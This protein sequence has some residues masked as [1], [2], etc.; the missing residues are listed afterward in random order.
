[1][2]DPGGD[3]TKIVIELEVQVK[4]LQQQLNDAQKKIEGFEAKQKGHRSR[5]TKDNKVQRNEIQAVQKAQQ[6]LVKTY[7]QAAKS[8]TRMQRAWGFIKK[9]VQ[10]TVKDVKAI[11]KHDLGKGFFGGLA[12]GTGLSGLYQSI[13]GQPGGPGMRQRLGGAIGRGAMGLA[14]AGLGKIA[15]GIQA[16][17]Q[18]YM[19]FGASQWGMAGLGSSKGD[20]GRG[21][22]AFGKGVG[23]GFTPTETAQMAPGVAGA[24]GHLGATTLAQQFAMGGGY[25]PGRVG[26]AVQYM[27]TMRQA[28]TDFGGGGKQASKELTKTISAGMYSGLEKARLPEFYEGVR[29]LV[30]AQFGTSAGKVDSVNIAK[31]L[32]MIGKGGGVGFQGARGAQVMGQLDQ[33]I[34]SP[35]GGEA[36]QAMILQAMGF[37]KPGGQVN[38]Y[39]ALK[40]QQ[41][42]IRDPDNIKKVMKEVYSQRGN[43][44]A[45]GA[46]PAN[47]EANLQFSLMSGLSIKQTEQLKDIYSSSKS[48]EEK[49]KEIEKVLEE[50]KPIQE[51]ALEASKDGFAAIKKHIAGVEA[52]QIRI[53]S[54]IAKPMMQLQDLQLKVLG[55]IADYLPKVIDYLKK[56]WDAIKEIGIFIKDIAMKV[57]GKSEAEYEKDI[58]GRYKNTIDLIKGRAPKTAQGFLTQQGELGNAA[59]S[60]ATEATKT[61]GIQSLLTYAGVAGERKDQFGAAMSRRTYGAQMDADAANT[62]SMA[63]I[64]VNEALKAKGLAQYATGPQAEQ[65]YG[66]M[67]RVSPDQAQ[68]MAEKWLEK[69]VDIGTKNKE[70][71][72]K[73][74][75]LAESKQALDKS[76]AE[77]RRRQEEREK[78]PAGGNPKHRGVGTRRRSATD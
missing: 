57:L 54:K 50:A 70:I 26:E 43:V 33:M 71:A 63:G 9:D 22:K 76:A 48:Q 27:G 65:I 74:A 53:G 36:G 46:D 10:H 18:Q 40:G 12:R 69:L 47:R 58:E 19:Q 73:Q 67:G 62:R 41:E 44:D 1:M 31:Q 75:A 45:G 2:P 39:D 42:G 17:Y 3:G 8:S 28:G 25:G 37:G 30:Q 11:A 77:W 20:R 14:S 7:E 68:M 64:Y 51:R 29:G 60:K 59:Y 56:L 72:E 78:N 32:A 21:R 6:L 52:Q 16:S 24:T 49:D 4:E 15:G 23:M 66:K 38:Y 13:R 55:I 5:R 61:S 35:G 34:K